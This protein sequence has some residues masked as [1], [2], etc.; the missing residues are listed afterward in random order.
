MGWLIIA[1]I[2][3]IT[4]AILVFWARI[5][6]GSWEFVAAAVILGIAGYAWQGNPSY[7]GAPKAAA[8]D[9]S[10][11][12][13]EA[14]RAM[15]QQRKGMDYEFSGARSWLVMAD[16]QSQQGKFASATVILKNAIEK[17]PENPD[18]WVALGNALVGHSDGFISPAAQYTFQKAANIA[19]DSPAP[20]YFLGLALAQSG[21][22]EEARSLWQSLLDRAPEDAPIR[23]QLESLIARVDAS[24]GANAQLTVPQQPGDDTQQTTPAN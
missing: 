13:N 20:P 17:Q 24:L 3:V 8:E 6:R 11:A 22:L 9:F 21:R 15:L 5:P 14:Q 19:P 23:A 1:L 12:D 16:A 2:A 4:L 10:E 7:A 18:L